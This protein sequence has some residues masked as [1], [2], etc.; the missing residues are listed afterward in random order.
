MDAQA[1]KDLYM[2]KVAGAFKGPKM[3]A[4]VKGIPAADGR[5]GPNIKMDIPGIADDQ[6]VGTVGIFDPE[7]NNPKAADYGLPPYM[8]QSTPMRRYGSFSHPTIPGGIPAHADFNEEATRQY[9][10]QQME[11]VLPGN[12]PGYLHK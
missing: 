11:G 3:A 8:R 4:M 12:M 7:P 5:I 2:Q 10:P 1:F 6:L 9:Y